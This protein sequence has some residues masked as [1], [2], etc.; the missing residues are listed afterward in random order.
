MLSSLRGH[1]KIESTVCY[2]RIEIGDAIE[3]AGKIEIWEVRTW[4]M[5]SAYFPFHPL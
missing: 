1:T 4:H 5:S 3:I 2:L